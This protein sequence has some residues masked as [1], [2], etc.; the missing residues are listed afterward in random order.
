MP[1]ISNSNPFEILVKKAMNTDEDSFAICMASWHLP[2]YK[3]SISYKVSSQREATA[4]EEYIMKAA[5]CEIPCDVDKAMLS[6]L[7]GLDEVF[8]ENAI[9]HL[10]DK[11]ILDTKSLPVLKLTES[12]GELLDRR[13]VLD[14]ER[15]EEIS[16]CINLKTAHVYSKVT[17]SAS[18]PLHPDYNRIDKMTENIKKYINRKFIRDV[19]SVLGNSTDNMSITEILSAKTSDAVKTLFTE[20][21]MYDTSK[22]RTYIKIWD[23]AAG[24]FR[25]DIAKLFDKISV[26]ST[27]DHEGA[28]LS[29]KSAEILNETSKDDEFAAEYSVNKTLIE[30]I[31]ENIKNKKE[32]GNDTNG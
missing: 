12:G 29:E 7:L 30:I 20:I 10:C 1:G 2:V 26:T 9:S 23:H 3:Q 14:K 17:E 28:V 4:I 32:E 25:D 11:G 15:D 6:E 31:I 21:L 13:M 16:Y 27:F 19:N 18:F 24:C 5:S 8:T 22:D